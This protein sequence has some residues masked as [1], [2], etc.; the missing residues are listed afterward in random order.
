MIG[1]SGRDGLAK[2]LRSR[3]ETWYIL[4]FEI[5]L[6]TRLLRAS[7]VSL[8]LLMSYVNAAR[9]YIVAGVE[10]LVTN[11]NVAKPVSETCP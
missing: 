5:L 10:S 11:I 4:K 9:V 7:I 1:G 3:Y 8:L 2:F 6:T